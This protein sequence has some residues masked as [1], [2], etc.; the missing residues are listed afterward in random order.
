[1][2]NQAPLRINIFGVRVMRY[3]TG[4]NNN[5]KKDS[6]VIQYRVVDPN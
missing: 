3:Y 4:L 2:L 6:A 1:M 5:L